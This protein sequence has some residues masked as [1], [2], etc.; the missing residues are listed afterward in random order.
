MNV[1]EQ[2]VKWCISMSARKQNQPARWCPGLK[3]LRNVV[4]S[5]VAGLSVGLALAVPNFGISAY[6]YDTQ[7]TPLPTS[8]TDTFRVTVGSTGDAP[9]TPVKVSIQVPAGVAVVPGSFPAYCTLVGT[10]AASPSTPGTQLLQCTLPLPNLGGAGTTSEISYVAKAFVPANAAYSFNACV[11]DT[12]SSPYPVS[13]TGVGCIPYPSDSDPSND[14]NGQSL[15]VNAANDLGISFNPAPNE[16]VIAGSPYTFTAKV[17]SNGLDAIPGNQV[18]AEFN[19][20]PG[21]QP[22]SIAAINAASP[23]WSCSQLG[24]K[25]TCVLA[26]AVAN[27]PSGTTTTL[28]DIKIPGTVVAGGGT[29]GMDA[30]V[31]SNDNFATIADPV[32]ANNGPIIKTLNVSAGG[33]VKADKSFVGQPG[34]AAASLALTATSTMRLTIATDPS[35]SAL[36]IGATISDDLTVMLAKGF[37]LLPAGVPPGCLFSTPNLVCTTTAPLPAGSLVNFDVV[38]THPTALPTPPTGINTAVVVAPASYTDTNSTDNSKTAS[39]VVVPAYADLEIIGSEGARK[40]P[41]GGDITRSVAV[42]N[43]GPLPVNYSAANP[44]RAFGSIGNLETV[45]GG[46]AGVPTCPG[47][48]VAPW[49]VCTVI[50]D[51][52]VQRLLFT[53]GTNTGVLAVGATS[54]SAPYTSQAPTAA[55]NIGTGISTLSCTGQQILDKTAVL[56][57]AGASPPER[58]GALGANVPASAPTIEYSN[59]CKN[60]RGVEYIDQAASTGDLSVTKTVAT[61][62][63]SSQICGPATTGFAAAQT[64]ASV[65]SNDNALCFKIVVTNNPANPAGWGSGG[66]YTHGTAKNYFISDT[67]PMYWGITGN[68]GEN[69]PTTQTSIL[70][71]AL[72][73]VAGETCAATNLGASPPVVRCD[74]KNLA[75]NASR[76]LYIKVARGMLDGTFTN[77]ATTDSK[78]LLEPDDVPGSTGFAPNTATAQSTVQPVVDLQVTGKAINPNPIAIGKLGQ[79]LF[80]YKNNG[81]NPSQLARVEDVIDT[82]RWEIVG[83]PVNTR[84]E[85]CSLVLNTPSAGRTTVRCD[86]STTPFERTQEFQVAIQV[87]PLFPYAQPSTSADGFSD[88]AGSPGY[89]QTGGGLG[90]GIPQSSMPGYTNTAVVSKTRAIETERDLTNNANSVLV[91]VAPPKFDLIVSKT[92]VGTLLNDDNLVYPAQVK[93]RI[94]MVNSGESK[95]TGVQMVDLKPVLTSGTVANFGAT[96]AVT[97]NAQ[98][99]TLNFVSAVFEPSAQFTSSGRALPGATPCTD[100]QPN[101]GQ[102]L[103]ISSATAADQ[104]MLPGESLSWV[105]TFV[106]SPATTPPIRGNLVLPNKVRGASNEAPFDMTATGKVDYDKDQ[107]RNATEN[108]TWFAPMDLEVTAK[109]TLAPTTI[110]LNQTAQFTIDFRN[111]GPSPTRRVKIVETLPPGFTFVTA[112]FVKP[113]GSAIPGAVADYPVSCTGVGANVATCEIGNTNSATADFVGATGTGQLLVTVKASNWAAIQTAG[114]D[115]TALNNVATISPG[116]DQTTGNPTG[117]DTVATNNAKT[118]TIAVLET[119][120]SGRVCKVTQ[121]ADL[122]AAALKNCAASPASAISG[123][124]IK[125]CGT[126]IFGNALGGGTPGTGADCADATVS[127]PTDANGDWKILVPPGT[128]T[129]VETQPSGFS[130]YTEQ[131]GTA[132]GT[133]AIGPNAAAPA[134]DFGP[135]AEENKISGVVVA[136]TGTQAARNPTGYNFTEIVDTGISGFVYEDLNNNGLKELGDPGIGGALLTLTGIDFDGNPVNVTTTSAITTGAY[137]FNVPPSNAAGYKLVQTQ[138]AGYYDGKDHRGNDTGAAVSPGSVI[139][140]SEANNS[141]LGYSTVGTPVATGTS[142]TPTDEITTIVLVEA[143]GQTQHNFGEIKPGTITG[144][145]YID[146]DG[147]VTKLAAET[148]LP[149][150]TITLTGTD[151]LGNA[152]TRTTVTNAVGAYEFGGLLPGNYNVSE[153]LVP[154]YKHTGAS[155]EGPQALGTPYALRTAATLTETPASGITAGFTVTPAINTIKLG[156]GGRSDGNNFGERGSDISGRVC[157]DLN[158]DGICQTAEPSIPGVTITLTGIDAGGNAITRTA[159]TSA[160]GSWVINDIPAPLSTGAGY[161]LEE[162]Q[163]PAFLD[164]KQSAGTLT[165]YG[166]PPNTAPSVGSTTATDVVSP[167]KDKITGIK[168]DQPT[169]G[170]NYDFAEVKPASLQGFVYYDVN[171]DGTRTTA[172]GQE[173]GIVGVVLE[174]TGTNDVGQTVALTTTTSVTPDGSYTFSNLRPGTYQVREIQPVAPTYTVIDGTVTVGTITY[175]TAGVTPAAGDQGTLVTETPSTAANAGE[176]VQG[177]VLRSGAAGTNYNFGEVPLVPVSGTVYVD[178]GNFGSLDPSETGMPNGKITTLVLCT[179]AGVPCGDASPITTTSTPG[180]GTYTFPPQPSGIYYVQEVQPAGYAS[181]TANVQTVTLVA[182]PVTNVNFGETGAN[183]SGTVY[184]D[185]FKDGVFS[186]GTDPGISGV[187]MKLCL[188]SAAAA[189]ATSPVATATTSLTGSYTFANIPAPPA[190][191]SYFISENEAT[192]PLTTYGNGTATVG[193]ITGSGSTPN[194]GSTSLAQQG[195]AFTGDSR[196]NLISFAMPTTTVVLGIQVEG[197]GY[198]FGEISSVGISGKVF[199]DR[200]FTNGTTGTFNVSTDRPLATVTITLCSAAPVAGV[201]SAIVGTTTTSITGDYNFANVSPGDYYVLETQPAGY[202]SSSPNVVSV[203]GF[204]A[205]TV[206]NVNFADTG[207]EIKGTVYQDNDNSGTLNTGDVGIGSVQV[208]LCLDAACATVVQTTNTTPGSGT[209]TFANVPTPPAGGYFIKEGVVPVGYVNGTTTAGT[210]TV[211]PASAGTLVG[212]ADTPNSRISGVAW[213]APTADFN[214][215]V[216]VGVAYN[217][218]ETGSP[219]LP[220]TNA[221][222]SGRVWLDG[223]NNGVIDAAEPGIGGVTIVLTGTS[224]GGPVTLTT[225]TANDGSY[226]FNGL[227]PGTYQVTQ[228][229]QPATSNGA[230]LPSGVS[231]TGQGITVPGTGAQQNG[232]ASAPTAVTSSIASIV[233]AAGNN[234]VNNN[235]GEVSGSTISGFV[236]NDVN[237]SGIKDQVDTPLVGVVV[238]LTGVDSTGQVITRTTTTDASGAYQFTGLP[239]GAYTVTEPVQPLGTANAETNPGTINNGGTAGTATPRATTPS[240]INGIRITAPGTTSPNNNF[241]EAPGST[242]SGFVYN[243]TNTSGVKDPADTP[244]AGVVITL[245]GVDSTGQAVTRT[246]TTDATGAYQFTGLPV[247]VYT[248]TEPVQPSGTANAETNPGT[249][250]NGGTAGTAS[251]RTTTPSAISG[252]RITAPGTDSPNNNFG[253]VT[254]SSIAGVVYRD[255]NGNQVRDGVEPTMPAGITVTLT[256]VDSAGTPVTRVTFT[257]ATG[258]YLFDNLRPGTYT[259]TESQPAGFATGGANPGTLAGGTGGPNSNVIS[260]INLPAGTDAI[261]YNFGDIPKPSSISG[262]VY[263]DDNGSQTRDGAETTMPAGITIT[264]TGVDINGT[265]VTRVTVTSATGTYLFDNLLPGTYSVT[266]SQPANFGNGGANPGTLAGGTGGPNSNVISNIILP[267]G[268]DA[269]NYNFG[270]VP[271]TA[272]V[273]GTVWRDNDHDRV[274]DPG[275]PVLPG[276]TVQVLRTPFGGGTPTLITSVVTD[277]NGFYQVTGLE[278]GSGYTVRFIAPNG[279]TFNGAV[280]GEQGTPVS[281]ATVVRGEITNLTLVAGSQGG[282]N[283]TPQQS[284]PVDPTG[285]VYDTDTRLPVPGAV[286]K[287]IAVNCPAFD[288]ARDLFGGIANQTQTVG[289][290]GFYQFILNPGAPLCEYRLVVT[291]PANFAVDTGTPPQPGAFTP[292]NRPPNDVFQLVPNAGAPQPGQPTTYY[293]GFNLNENSRDVVNNHIPLVSTVRPVIFISKVVDKSKAEIGDTVKYTVRVRYVKGAVNLTSLNVIDS[294]P[295][296][297]KLVPDTSFVSVSAGAAVVKLAAANI[298]GAPGAVVTYTMPLPAGG[299]A[300]GSEIELTYRVR[301]AVGSMQG[302]GINRAQAA[303][304]ALRSNTAQAKVVVEAGVFTSDACVAGKVFVDC[305]NNHVQDAEE[306]GVPGVRLYMEDGTYFITDSEGK[307][308]YCGLSPKSHVLTVDM[309][310]MPRGARMTTT[311]NRNLGDGNSLF[312]DVKNGQLVRADFAEGSCSNTM[313]EQ[314][315]RRRTQGEVRSTETEKTGQPALKFEGKSPQYPQQGT[316]SANQP[317]VVPRSTNGGAE[318]IPEQNTPVP[319]MPGASGNTQGANVRTAP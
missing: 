88:G 91:K 87:R 140:G 11:D 13:A 126:D 185:L 158:N 90:L 157:E 187:A 201:C 193:T 215:P 229:Q 46:A 255:D 76:T 121:G 316:D 20:Q 296:G 242:I 298:K 257:S 260:S 156:P 208:Q 313:L 57:S 8:K 256:G 98:V 179:T 68:P 258:T 110:N 66:P 173:V 192:G 99:R 266:E 166:T 198:N 103:C 282:Q 302:D 162:S 300:P 41:L 102:V 197:L 281:G 196:I 106:P 188:T 113:S 311:S 200:D 262:V 222:L 319:Q 291:S 12:F 72:D 315:K 217:F 141:A 231:Q 130:D 312:L 205:T 58:T 263:R 308:S 271:K 209:Y 189:C 93:Y 4:L 147:S 65:A 78:D 184:A 169:N 82:T 286:V 174:L 283:I 5:L 29:T 314:V 22:A 318:S 24:S 307:Y 238:T 75:A 171:K 145:V 175:V 212:T 85:A 32:P 28:P 294:M 310:T 37:Q 287:L 19:V 125:L 190:G 71:V 148:T 195:P 86:L 56:I 124:T 160:T 273:S 289:A 221:N 284:L 243:D 202:G 89:V 144:V 50:T 183:L 123:T 186:G 299:L 240:A 48:L 168:F 97:N 210:L 23:G 237:A 62:T 26:A 182:L 223:N 59:D 301:L 77:T 251:P 129:V 225:V 127:A 84:G 165:P 290:D 119:S 101:A 153:A 252:I 228:P 277:A 128:Y 16:S 33:N 70:D 118:S 136:A 267:A 14:F 54:P 43:N 67:L 211:A 9:T 167:A 95:I 154:G 137:Q 176:R 172:S 304:G 207:A 116:T 138:P 122:T 239:V 226:S 235:F 247:G 38:L 112:T 6:N 170:T 244:L 25:I 216:A 134:L 80:T 92:D 17:T 49:S 34:A 253:E 131:A 132:G 31:A 7:P 180:S 27:N 306:L 30:A 104:Y 292:P 317:L 241:G 3:H 39:Y 60:L 278:A 214:G 181:S 51:S 232:L 94:T 246:T 18:Q 248:V 297:F 108:T 279:V 268:T 146:S 55:A 203:L 44:L 105:L 36:P 285:V 21:F 135:S 15:L 150:V 254:A 269:P 177:I 107:A 35:G 149:N 218:G 272:G 295:A 2:K 47:T 142:N 161:T 69:L 52:G 236:Y 204:G 100:G 245:T 288:P 155:V 42:R 111:N 143:V 79:Y 276:W 220:P 163:P 191:D 159:V 270:D 81:P 274:R 259:V 117:K 199:L 63:A 265:P 133:V 213:P 114:F 227:Q 219:V 45:G 73:T 206:A 233:L 10:A 139:N 83:T 303:V 305:N 309:L 261:N 293:L 74:L 249:V 164:G 275:E 224:S 115:P 120:I 234:S 250:N 178:T 40:V 264:L 280:D 1:V 96:T 194:N 151:F 61:L 64:L 152:V 230:T 53:T 109:T